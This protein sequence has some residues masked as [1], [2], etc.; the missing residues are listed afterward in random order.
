MP[1]HSPTPWKAKEGNGAYGIVARD[2]EAFSNEKS[3]KALAGEDSGMPFLGS[4]ISK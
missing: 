4:K 3:C 2:Q 1:S